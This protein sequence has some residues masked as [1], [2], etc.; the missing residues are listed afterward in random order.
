VIDAGVRAPGI[1]LFEADELDQDGFS[2][3]VPLGGGLTGPI[4]LIAVVQNDAGARLQSEPVRITVQ[5]GDSP[6]SFVLSPSTLRLDLQNRTSGRVRLTG[7]YD[8]GIELDFSHPS[9]GTV[10]Q[11]VNPEIADVDSEGRVVALAQGHTVIIAT[12]GEHTAFASVVVTSSIGE[13]LPPES[14]ADQIEIQGSGFRLNRNSGFF[15][16]EL[17]V[18][19]RQPIPVRGPLLIRLNGLADGVSLVNR[20]TVTRHLEPIGEPVLQ[21][22]LDGD[23]ITL[24]PGQTRTLTL[25][26]LNPQRLPVRY[27]PMIYRSASGL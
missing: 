12:N 4:T 19:N 22:D 5:P 10:Y 20:D 6:Q 9:M 18:V 27:T 21:V 25:Q 23:G 1:G 8:N 24:Q 16:Q 26:F 3:T 13:T 11:S 2:A 15:V 17:V 14:V 7:L